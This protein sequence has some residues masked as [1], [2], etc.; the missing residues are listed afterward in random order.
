[1]RS[2]H[3]TLAVQHFFSGLA[4]YVFQT[5]LGV[6][7]PPLVDYVSDL[8]C[9][10]VRWDALF[11]VRDWRDAPCT[12]SWRWWRRPSSGR[13]MLGEW[14][15]ATSG[16]LRCSGWACIRMRCENCAVR[17]RKIAWSITVP[18]ASEPTS[19]PARSTTDSEDDPPADLL[20]RLSV[21]FELCALGLRQVRRQWER[22]LLRLPG[23]G[24]T[25]LSASKR[26]RMCLPPRVAACVANQ[27][28]TLQ[29]QI[30]PQ[31]ANLLLA[32]GFVAAGSK[33]SV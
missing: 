29:P 12:R 2:E 14:F 17:T 11:A 33:A 8:I 13:A 23:P 26:A 32:I 10:F 25:T 4:E 28:R 9:R 22:A 27:D 3:P 15:I 31:A 5:Q 7:D 19:W 21:Q 1:M 16:I 18:K 24:R 6:A 20:Q 30:G